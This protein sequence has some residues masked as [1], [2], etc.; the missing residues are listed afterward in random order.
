MGESTVLLVVVTNRRDAAQMVRWLSPQL[1]DGEVSIAFGYLATVAA[2]DSGARAVVA[3][4]GTP[5]G[6]DHW[7]LAELRARQPDTATVVVADAAL[8][9][10][11]AGTVR[12]DLAVTGVDALPPLRELLVTNEPVVRPAQTSWRRSS[13]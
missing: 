13:R 11:L 3:D 4:V 9:P 12:A 8:L 7:R 10:Q 6:R 2:I 5:D 1:P